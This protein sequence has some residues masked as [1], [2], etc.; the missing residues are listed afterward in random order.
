MANGIIIE[1]HPAAATTAAVEATAAALR[2]LSDSGAGGLDLAQLQQAC[3]V[4]GDLD[5]KAVE[6]E[7]SL[8]LY[9]RTR[10]R[11]EWLKRA[12]WRVFRP[13]L[14]AVPQQPTATAGQMTETELYRAILAQAV[15]ISQKKL[16]DILQRWGV[17]RFSGLADALRHYVEGATDEDLTNIIES[18]GQRRPDPA[19]RWIG[20]QSDAERFAKAAGMTAAGF[21]HAFGRDDPSNPQTLLRFGNM[22]EPKQATADR[23]NHPK[24]LTII[25]RFGLVAP[26]K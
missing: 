11:F 22:K 6:N 10:G 7:V 24:I 4:L 26:E 19:P 21:N 23:S 15:L 18:N 14:A 20:T 25:E 8:F 16:S 12:L 17:Y 13:A 3:N 2:L 9:D 1:L 5:F